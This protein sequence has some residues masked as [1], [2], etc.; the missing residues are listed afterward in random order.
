MQTDQVKNEP[1]SDNENRNKSRFQKGTS[2]NVPV[3]EDLVSLSQEISREEHVKLAVEREYQ[4]CYA[5]YICM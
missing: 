4:V 2:I 3:E 1:S 5:S